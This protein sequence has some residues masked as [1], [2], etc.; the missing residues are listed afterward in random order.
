LPS[1][2]CF[3]WEAPERYLHGD[4]LASADAVQGERRAFD[5][6][7]AAFRAMLNDGGYEVRRDVG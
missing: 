1:T 2:P 5:D 3:A 7:L 4:D 6:G